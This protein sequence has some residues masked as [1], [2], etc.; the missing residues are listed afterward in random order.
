[1]FSVPGWNVPSSALTTQTLS[2][3]AV[4]KKVKKAE[5]NKA[6]KQKV[7][8]KKNASD[9]NQ[10]P[11]GRRRG[12]A[13]D[14]NGDAG[15]EAEEAV[16][17]KAPVEKKKKK[18]ER[19][20]QKDEGKKDTREI[21]IGGEDKGPKVTD[22]NLQTLYEKVI[23]GKSGATKK[24]KRGK[25][26]GSAPAS[27]DAEQA[28]EGQIKEQEPAKEESTSI[29][30]PT[31]TTSSSSQPPRKKQKKDKSS[32]TTPIDDLLSST[33][34]APSAIP[35]PLASIP[36]LTPL[37]QKMRAKLT[38]ARFRH[39]NESL[40]T[41]PSAT[42]FSLFRTQPSMFHDYHAGFRQQV[43]AWPENPVDIFMKQLLSRASA[44]AV[45]KDN[46]V[47]PKAGERE[48]IKP[49]P[50]PPPTYACTIADLGCGDA[51][52]A[53][54]LIPISQKRNLNLKIH[55]FDLTSSGNPLVTEADIANLPLEPESVDI[56]IF[57][58]ALMGTNYLDFLEEAFRVLR[59]GGELWIAEIKS[60][61]SNAPI[62]DGVGAKGAGGAKGAQPPPVSSSTEMGN[63]GK[64]G[65]LKTASGD[66]D[67]HDF[68]GGDGDDGAAPTG[69]I[70]PIYTPFITALS[71]RG[72]VLR[73]DVRGNFMV[74]DSN[75]M[76]VRM[77]FL[78]PRPKV[79]RVRPGEGNPDYDLS[80]E[81]RGGK[82]GKVRERERGG[83]MKRGK[84]MAET[85]EDV[86]KREERL[87]KPCVYKLR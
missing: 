62:A 17:T 68:P 76:F 1:M 9:E 38:S 19:I 22:E 29:K 61:F 35:P 86:R 10:V 42:S 63:Q 85:A 21:V 50:R 71:R 23:E 13:G 37:Q 45:P 54:T 87:L 28:A 14:A 59:F 64:I 15:A 20:E 5:Q 69:P 44:K 60:R 16:V 65:V 36:A 51:K 31:T 58:L 70:N 24:R 27:G 84:W 53:A 80:R 43:Q 67:D 18:E 46:K 74:D 12:E 33:N 81:G 6:Q 56:A 3:T 32:K 49:L 55:S 48:Q 2:A 34:P 8:R 83:E 41:A 52:L 7:K 47:K 40:Y 77:E 79:E 82:G 25:K 72:F 30:P 73:T 11:L 57:C 75:K 39:L 78:K 66:L 26:G 4:A